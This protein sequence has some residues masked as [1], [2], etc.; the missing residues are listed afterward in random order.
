[1]KSDKK[2]VKKP[3]AKTNAKKQASLCVVHNNNL[4]QIEP[5]KT[6]EKLLIIN[7][8]KLI[9][10]VVVAPLAKIPSGPK[11]ATTQHEVSLPLGI[12][13]II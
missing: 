12:Q 7:K 2:K 1:M 13:L 8:V 4:R 10:P 9:E 6:K 5:F 3:A 11:K